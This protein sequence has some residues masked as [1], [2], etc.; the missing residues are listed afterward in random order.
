MKEQMNRV[1]RVSRKFL[2]DNGREATAEELSEIMNLPKAKEHVEENQ[3]I[4]GIY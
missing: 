2:L 3:P 1:S 4:E